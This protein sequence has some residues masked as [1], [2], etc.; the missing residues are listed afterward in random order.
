MDLDLEKIGCWV[1][2][3]STRKT[4]SER[5]RD[6]EVSDESRRKEKKEKTKRK[7]KRERS[8]DSSEKVEWHRTE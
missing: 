4:E 8:I 2:G 7:E 3:K 5:L 1:V 6:R